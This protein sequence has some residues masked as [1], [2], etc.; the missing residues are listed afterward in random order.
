[1]GNDRLQT[2]GRKANAA[3]PLDAAKDNAGAERYPSVGRDDAVTASGNPKPRQG[4]GDGSAPSSV[5]E[6]RLGPGADPAEGKR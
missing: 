4:A 2:D 1:M 6:G 3:L 5:N